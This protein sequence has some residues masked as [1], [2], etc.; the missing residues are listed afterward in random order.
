MEVTCFSKRSL[1]PVDYMVLYISDYRLEGT[2]DYWTEFH[3]IIGTIWYKMCE[4][5]FYTTALLCSVR[6]NCGAGANILSSEKCNV[7]I[8]MCRLMFKQ[9]SFT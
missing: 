1:Y 2:K 3:Y 4:K 7:N 8:A 6:W 5:E 9:S